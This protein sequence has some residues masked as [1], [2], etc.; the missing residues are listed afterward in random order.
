[1]QKKHGRKAH[2]PCLNAIDQLNEAKQHAEDEVSR[3]QGQIEKIK[4]VLEER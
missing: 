1:M 3:L 2:E 4:C